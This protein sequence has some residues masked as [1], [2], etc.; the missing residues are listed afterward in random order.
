MAPYLRSKILNLSDQNVVAI[1]FQ[2]Y[3]DE[4]ILIW[5]SKF[6]NSCL[7]FYDVCFRNVFS[8]NKE[9]LPLKL[10][11]SPLSD[12]S[13]LNSIRILIEKFD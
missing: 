13:F 1:F 2:F 7:L 3:E 6:R 9:A 12:D 4:V 10:L 8:K 5:Y 11:L